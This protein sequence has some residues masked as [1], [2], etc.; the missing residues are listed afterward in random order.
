MPREEETVG[1]SRELGV[2][3]AQRAVGGKAEAGRGGSPCVHFMT[4]SQQQRDDR[5]TISRRGEKNMAESLPGMIL[6]SAVNILSWW[7]FLLERR[8]LCKKR[9]PLLA[10]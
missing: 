5:G 3:E 1:T 8:G 9:F 4:L 7:R 2:Y 6:G 10:S